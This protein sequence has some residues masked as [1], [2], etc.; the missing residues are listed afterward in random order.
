MQR[1]ALTLLPFIL[2]VASGATHAAAPLA[3][4]YSTVET[5]PAFQSAGV[6]EAGANYHFVTNDFGDWFGQYL[7]GEIQTDP[8]N[9][10]NAEALHQREFGGSGFYGAVGNTHVF[11]EDWYSV[12]NIGAGADAEFL[13]RYRIDVFLNRKWLSQRQLVTT[14]GVGEYKAMDGQH[15]DRSLFLGSSYYF[16]TIPWIVQGGIR[17][18]TSDPGGVNST[19]QFVAVTQG[20][21]KDHFI[22]LRYGFGEEAYQIIDSGQTLSD[23]NSQVV[24]LQVKKWVGDD[25]GFNTQAERYHNPNYDRTGFTFGL[26]KEF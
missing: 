23:F 13:P 19:S 2:C 8:N 18:N 10:W 4:D 14:I 1:K 20:R 7:K 6:V 16:Q 5:D 12:V 17:F 24:S 22:T 3:D 26:F 25:W 21:N 11:N 15:R 9:R